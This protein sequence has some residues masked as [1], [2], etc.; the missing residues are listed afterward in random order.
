MGDAGPLIRK[1]TLSAALL[2]FLAGT[3][4][5]TA[6]DSTTVRLLGDFAEGWAEDWPE[7]TFSREPNRIRVVHEGPGERVL[8]FQSRDA[9]GGIWRRFEVDPLEEAT[10]SWRWKVE[11][12]LPGRPDE[13]E[14]AG[15]DYAARVFVIYR[16]HLLLPWMTRA[17]CYVWSG[18][19]PVGEIFPNPGAGGVKT[20]VLQSGDGEAGSWVREERDLVADHVK[21][22]GNRPERVVGFAIMVDTDDTGGLARARFDDLDLTIP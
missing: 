17:I 14:K 3:G 8:E 6:D 4:T 20:I 7:R 1:G 21:A 22:F 13:R 5:G 12:S 9:A 19:R 2:L 16:S 11:A 10:L 15:D 18:A